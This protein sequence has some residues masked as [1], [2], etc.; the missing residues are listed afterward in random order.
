MNCE[1]ISQ[2]VS[3]TDSTVNLK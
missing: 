3:P 1:L 2:T